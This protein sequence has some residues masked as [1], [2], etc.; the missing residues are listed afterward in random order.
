MK[1]SNSLWK[2]RLAGAM[3]EP[4]AK[5]IDAFEMEIEL[6]RQGKVDEKIFAETRLAQRRAL[7][8]ISIAVN[9]GILGFFKYGNFLMENWVW[10]MS[11]AGIEWQAGTPE[12][13]KIIEFWK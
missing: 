2:E 10:L 8:T 1:S 4:L 5:E 7:L 13:K 12:V 6:R 11:Q 3:P 9:L